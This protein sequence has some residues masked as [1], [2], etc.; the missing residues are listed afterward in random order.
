MKIVTIVGARP[1]FIKSAGISRVLRQR[2]HEVLVHTGQHYDYKM[3]GIFFEGLELPPPNYDLGVGSGSHGEQ[4]GAMLKGI[5]RVLISEVPDKALI[6]GDTNSTLA[7]ALAA[8]KL[9]IPVIHV[10]AGLRSFNRR[11]PEEINRVVA[12]HLSDV[13]LCPSLTSVRNLASEGI[14]ENV[15]LVSDVMLDVLNWARPRALEKTGSVLNRMGIEPQRYLLV[16]VHRGEN[17]DEAERLAAI[18]KALNA[19]GEPVVFPV[20][21]RTQKALKRS[22]LRLGSHV[23]VIDPVGYLEMVALS[24]SARMIL[25]DSG[26]LQKEAYWLGIPCLTLRDETEWIET[27]ESGWNNLVGINGDKIIEAVRSF[28]PPARR[29]ELYGDGKMAG[30][31][32]PFLA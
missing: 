20:H 8:S 28:C 9:H 32:L 4:T 30:R 5:E 15:H 21:P 26:G 24:G 17:T 1:Q 3:A 12:D 13:L 10:E 27:V 16:T 22:A 29:E 23:R 31:I 19:L 7:G 14:R 25:T 2:F 11:M 18:V 6:Y